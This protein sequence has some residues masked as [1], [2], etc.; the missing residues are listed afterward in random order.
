MPRISWYLRLTENRQADLLNSREARITPIQERTKEDF[1]LMLIKF[2]ESFVNNDELKKQVLLEELMKFRNTNKLEVEN[3]I[4]QLE[5]KR[6]EEEIKQQDANLK[7]L[8]EK[9]EKESTALRRDLDNEKK[10]KL[11]VMNQM[12]KSMETEKNTRVRAYILLSGGGGEDGKDMNEVRRQ[13]RLA[14]NQDDVDWLVIAGGVL[15]RQV[16]REGRGYRERVKHA[17]QHEKLQQE[18]RLPRRRP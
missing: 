16:A 15:Q 1:N 8:K 5:L 17:N 10:D 3:L 6:K 18:D 11:I 7:S 9:F 4:L 12:V 2:A 14:Q 13:D